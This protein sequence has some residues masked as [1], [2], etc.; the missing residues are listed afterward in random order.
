MRYFLH[1]RLYFSLQKK[2]FFSKNVYHYKTLL[3][4][5]NIFSANIVYFVK[6]SFAT[7]EQPYTSP[8]CKKYLIKQSFSRTYQTF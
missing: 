2:F 3:S 8:F 5:K 7:N 6:N 4:Y 1:F